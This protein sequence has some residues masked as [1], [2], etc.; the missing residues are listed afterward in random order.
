MLTSCLHN[1]QFL[2]SFNIGFIIEWMYPLYSH[3]QCVI[4]WCTRGA[5]CSL[6]RSDCL[7]DRRLSS[8]TSPSLS[9][10]RWS[11]MHRVY[12]HFSVPPV[13]SGHVPW[14][15]MTN[16]TLASLFLLH[17]TLSS[18]LGTLELTLLSQTN[19]TF[20]FQT[21]QELQQPLVLPLSEILNLLNTYFKL[22]S[23]YS[24]LHVYLIKY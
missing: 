2:T 19:F 18:L 23:M 9:L 4:A 6:W 17:F 8:L 21:G 20:S 5:G 14:H 24:N 16:I 13:F 15:F 3:V 22:S 11:R 1:R 10:S 12:F 7:M